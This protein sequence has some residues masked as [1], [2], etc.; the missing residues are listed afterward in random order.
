MM[1]RRHRE[2]GD[3]H[4]PATASQRRAFDHPNTEKTL[5]L[6]HEE[7]ARDRIRE[8]RRQAEHGR[9]ERREA[10]ARRWHRVAHWAARRAAHFDR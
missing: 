8:L 5:M 7:L 6:L 10:A 4:S 1:T 2:A 3:G 9:A